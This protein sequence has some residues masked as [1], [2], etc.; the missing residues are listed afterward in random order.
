MEIFIASDLWLLSSKI[1][2]MKT[3][4]RSPLEKGDLIMQDLFIG[5]WDTIFLIMQVEYKLYEIEYY[6]IYCC[7]YWPTADK[8]RIISYPQDKNNVTENIHRIF[9]ASIFY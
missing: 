1:R 8:S 9:S 6:R 7:T 4:E 5:S 2:T 3:I